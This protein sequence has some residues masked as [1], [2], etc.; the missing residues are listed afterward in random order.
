MNDVQMVCQRSAQL[1]CVAIIL[2]KHTST[3]SL[4]VQQR[5]VA[6][7]IA[8]R[9]PPLRLCSLVLCAYKRKCR[10]RRHTILPA[11]GALSRNA[12][13]EYANPVL[14][15]GLGKMGQAGDPGIVTHGRR[16]QGR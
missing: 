3:A 7:C 6:C 15:S 14:G 8:S 2:C 9:R 16:G 10:A 4:I 13:L 12:I 1:A 11:R 5:V